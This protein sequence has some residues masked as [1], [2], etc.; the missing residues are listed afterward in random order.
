MSSFY[1]GKGITIYKK[2][3]RQMLA[4]SKKALHLARIIIHS[5]K[6]IKNAIRTLR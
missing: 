2:K 5:Q 3:V 4:V 1:K 6:P